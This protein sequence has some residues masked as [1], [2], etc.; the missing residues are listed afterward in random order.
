MIVLRLAGALLLTFSGA[1]VA[2]MINAAASTA[3]LQTEGFISFL[4][5]TRVHI[6]C[7]SLP[8]GDIIAICEKDVLL[9]CG[10]EKREA[11]RSFDLF[12]DSIIVSDK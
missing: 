7:F 4:R 9:R 11:P 1:F 5:F 12:V 3:L 2:R 6:D 8:I 10:Y